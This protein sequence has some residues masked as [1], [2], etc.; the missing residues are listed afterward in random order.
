MVQAF[1]RGLKLWVEVLEELLGSLLGS[2]RDI[3][4]IAALVGVGFKRLLAV[5]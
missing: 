4:E 1:F 2:F 3:L 5:V